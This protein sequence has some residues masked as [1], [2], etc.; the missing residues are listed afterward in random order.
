MTLIVQN[1]LDP[2]LVLPV[3]KGGTGT[4][5][6]GL[7][8]GT[9]VTITG[10]WPNQIIAGPASLTG[11]TGA[12][13]IQG[14]TGPTGSVGPAGTTGLGFAIAKIY[15]SVAALTADT[16]PTGIIA[17]QFAIIDTGNSNNAEDAKLYLWNGSTYTYTTDLSGASGIQGPQGTQGVTGPTGPTGAQGIQGIQGVTGPTGPTGA[18][19]IQ[20][21]QGI[22]GTT[23]PTG[24]QGIQGVTGPTGAQGL[25][26]ADSTI[27]GPTGAQGIQGIQ[28]IQ[29][30]TGVQGV[31]GI[32]GIQGIQ[33]VTGPTGA[34][35]TIAGPTGPTGIQGITGPTGS[36]TGVAVWDEDGFVGTFTNLNFVGSAVT[37]TTQSTNS[38]GYAAITVN[39]SNFATL[40][41]SQSI[42]NKT[43]KTFKENVSITDPFNWSQTSE[44]NLDVLEAPIKIFSNQAT[45]NFVINVR[46]DIFTTL[47]S[48]LANNE[49]ITVNFFVT[50]LYGTTYYPTAF[51]IDGVT[52]TPQFQGGSTVVSG[53]GS[54]LYVMFIVKVP[55]DWRV[56]VSQT[57]F[58]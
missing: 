11:P 3:A 39:T 53:N 2:T 55:G 43:I 51:K 29:G 10:S 7:V 44:V 18:Q 22:Q 48:I 30:P 58:G 26:G 24:T 34:A 46:G 5:T 42:S 31:Q 37:A 4:S 38:G 40:T 27:V 20:G 16:S 35:S 17:G 14:A 8:A 41:G 6:P 25:A 15:P 33:G 21:I 12:Q 54:D 36:Q 52:V 1:A 49:S 19:G 57:K 23:G 9:N 56:Y 28:G 32:Q 13:G 47:G 50:N 45:S